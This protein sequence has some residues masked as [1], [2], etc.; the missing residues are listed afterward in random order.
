[1]I[2]NI[3]VWQRWKNKKRKPGGGQRVSHSTVHDR[4]HSVFEI[5]N[6]WWC[7]FICKC[8]RV[9]PSFS[10]TNRL[11]LHSFMDADAILLLDAVEFINAAQTTI[12]QDQGSCFQVP[13][14]SILHSCYCQSFG[15]TFTLWSNTLVLYVKIYSWS[16][17]RVTLHFLT[18]LPTR[19]ILLYFF[20]FKSS[21]AILL[22]PFKVLG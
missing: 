15:N 9:L 21:W 16:H 8:M 18:L 14:T 1:M 7:E 17:V 11:L 13:V 19:Q 4:G 5:P 10:N 20:F 2:G 3:Q 6:F 22:G 12:C